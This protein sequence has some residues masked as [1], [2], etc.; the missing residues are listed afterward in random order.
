MFCGSATVVATVVAE[1]QLF[2]HLRNVYS[3]ILSC[4]F[5]ILT[6]VQNLELEHFNFPG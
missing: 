6:L 3:Y 1:P 2:L 5:I 4:W